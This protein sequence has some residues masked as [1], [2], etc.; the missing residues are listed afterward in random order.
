MTDSATASRHAFVAL[1]GALALVL[2]SCGGNPPTAPAATPTLEATASASGAPGTPEAPPRTATP[3]GP[4]VI[5]TVVPSAATTE[6]LARVEAAVVRIRGANLSRPVTRQFVTT[7]GMRALIDEELEDTEAIE[8]VRL[9][10]LLLEALGMVAPRTELL[11]AYRDLLGE[12]VLG[13]YSPERKALYVL[14][15]A[16]PGPIELATYAHEYHHALQDQRFDLEAL[17][18]AVQSNRDASMALSTLI[19][20]DAVLTQTQYISQELG[21]AG[22]LA[23]L[24]AAS[25]A[26]RPTAP[27]VLLDLLQFPY[28]QGLPFVQALAANGRGVS[29]I[30]AAFA[31]P[32]DSTEQVLH[33]EKFRASERPTPVA[34]APALPS[35]WRLAGKPEGDVLGEYLLRRWLR[36][37]GLQATSAQTAAAGWG[38]DRF[39]VAED[40]NGVRGLV[41]RIV[42]DTPADADEFAAVLI[43]GP[44]SDGLRLASAGRRWVG[45]VRLDARTLLLV[46]GADRPAAE[47]LG[48]A[49]ASG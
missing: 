41:A 4:R 39:V 2:A 40:P 14:A 45:L 28:L 9:E 23:L 21:P 7:A 10:G 18:D 13:L 27:T 6:Q 31:R 47:A 19:E 1:L 33:P 48:R 43:P 5:E 46:V 16:E 3:T 49:A 34:F 30:D 24:G 12:Q 44:P 32:P 11:E 8:S 22:A 36:D 20:G 37:S 26:P 42:W 17:S 29:G 15:N 35:G 25:A 38:G